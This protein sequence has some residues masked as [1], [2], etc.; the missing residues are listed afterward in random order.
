MKRLLL[1]ST[2]SLLP[3]SVYGMNTT[4]AWAM[5]QAKTR[6]LQ[7][8]QVRKYN[9]DAQ[10]MNRAPL[11]QSTGI[12]IHDENKK[13]VV[14]FVP[15]IT[16]PQHNHPTILGTKHLF[17]IDNAKII[18]AMSNGK[19]T[20]TPLVKKQPTRPFSA[21]R[22]IPLNLLPFKKRP[23]PARTVTRTSP[24]KNQQTTHIYIS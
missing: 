16:R 3:A 20:V 15:T 8:Q 13:I 2:I 9:S 22:T 5:Y 21:V 18:A 1:V 14:N 7:I 24:N 23:I 19:I 17:S 4:N 12:K 10:I 6:F 11:H